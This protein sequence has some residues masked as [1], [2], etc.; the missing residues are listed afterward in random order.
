[1]G[2]T[3]KSKTLA[4]PPEFSRHIFKFLCFGRPVCLDLDLTSAA[5]QVT[6]A[7]PDGDALPDALPDA[8]HVRS[9]HARPIS[10]SRDIIFKFLPLCRRKG[11]ELGLTIAAPQV[12]GVLPDRDGDALLD[13]TSVALLDGQSDSDDAS[14]SSCTSSSSSASVGLI[15]R[16]PSNAPSAVVETDAVALEDEAGKSL[17]TRGWDIFLFVLLMPGKCPRP[18]SRC[19]L[20]ALDALVLVVPCLA[21]LSVSETQRRLL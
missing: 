16:A 19:V 14:S 10:I 7:L 11:L 20:Y 21:C 18:P 9:S 15:E 3:G 5:P 13:A 2:G 6:G 8:L 1:M 4:R 12:T 17:G